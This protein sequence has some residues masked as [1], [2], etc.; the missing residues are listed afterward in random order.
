MIHPNCV[1]D[2]VYQ[3]EE[4]ERIY[5]SSLARYE[6]GTKTESTFGVKGT[7]I[8]PNGD[9]KKIEVKTDE[10]LEKDEL[11]DVLPTIEIKNPEESSSSES[12]NVPWVLDHCTEDDS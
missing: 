2:R 3:W 4:K 11:I 9:T 1:I 5:Q 6:D 10:F 12:E 7:R 8:F